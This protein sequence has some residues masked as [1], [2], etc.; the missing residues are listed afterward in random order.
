MLLISIIARVFGAFGA[1]VT[2][3]A[4]L[5]ATDLEHMINACDSDIAD[6]VSEILQC[7]T[8]DN[9]PSSI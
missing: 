3:T 8:P 2:I 5:F 7:W 1:V 6:S 9:G 4:Q